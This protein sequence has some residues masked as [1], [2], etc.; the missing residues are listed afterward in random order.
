MCSIPHRTTGTGHRSLWRKVS[1]PQRETFTRRTPRPVT[2]VTDREEK[3]RPHRTRAKRGPSRFPVDGP[4][5]LDGRRPS[6]LGSVC[7]EMALRGGSQT[8][9][10]TVLRFLSTTKQGNNLPSP[11]VSLSPRRITGWVVLVSEKKRNRDEGRRRPGAE[12]I[13]GTPSSPWVRRG[14]LG[15]TPVSVR[16]RRLVP[17]GS[18]PTGRPCTTR[19]PRHPSRDVPSPDGHCDKH[20]SLGDRSDPRRSYP[21]VY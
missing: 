12:V 8:P 6:N 18:G 16:V 7:G 4:L 9:P 11:T 5:V 1:H 10:Q 15:R 21:A 2:R 3:Q 19:H 20:Y 13:V 14:L 17:S